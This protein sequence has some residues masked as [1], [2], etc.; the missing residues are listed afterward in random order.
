MDDAGT[1][2]QRLLAS[3]ALPQAWADR[4]A[5]TVL[6]TDFATLTPFL[7]CWHTWQTD[8]QRPRMLHYVGLLA[9]AQAQ[10][11]SVLARQATQNTPQWRPLADALGAACADLGPGQHHPTKHASRRVV[12]PVENQIQNQFLV[13]LRSRRAGVT[14]WCHAHRRSSPVCRGL[15][16]SE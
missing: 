16:Q 2:P 8:T 12:H 15:G 5:W 14:G 4:P 9:P 6:D 13:L 3:C 1:L 7:H 10:Q 11:L